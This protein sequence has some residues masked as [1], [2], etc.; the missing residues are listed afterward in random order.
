MA[1][2]QRL[3]EAVRRSGYGDSSAYPP[4][5]EHQ[6][7]IDDGER[8]AREYGLGLWSACGA[9]DVPLTAVAPVAAEPPGAA[10]A[11]DGE[12]NPSAVI[13][14]G[15]APAPAIP[16]APAREPVQPPPP[17]VAQLAATGCD[18]SYPDL[19][20]PSFPDLDCGEVGASGFAVLPPDPHGF[21]GDGDGVGCEG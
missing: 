11:P 16:A 2:P 21:D 17:V 7:R 6:D 8:F 14:P 1:T 15:P 3:N 10:T 20:L 5:V 12:E 13:E 19:C 9:P 18:P 4:D